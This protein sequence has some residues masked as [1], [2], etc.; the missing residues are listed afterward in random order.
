MQ[1][2]VVDGTCSKKQLFA[3]ALQDFFIV[4]NFKRCSHLSYG[5][6]DCLL[7][8]EGSNF[9][10]TSTSGE[11]LHTIDGLRSDA[12]SGSHSMNL[13]R[14]DLFYI[15]KDYNIVK[16]SK[17]KENTKTTFIKCM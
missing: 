2:D 7:I 17:Y 11:T 12:R 13:S 3:P 16:L 4:T 14:E 15:E 6:S 8:N 9:I 1:H 5:T 10:I